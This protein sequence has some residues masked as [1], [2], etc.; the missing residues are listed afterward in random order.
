[1]VVVPEGT[2]VSMLE[3]KNWGWTPDSHICDVTIENKCVNGKV[4]YRA[5]LWPEGTVFKDKE[6]FTHGALLVALRM[7]G[8]IP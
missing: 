2:A 7:E 5:R 8:H 3:G 6:D 1:M 4:S